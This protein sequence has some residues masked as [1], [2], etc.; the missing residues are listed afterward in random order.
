[1]C[2]KW[3]WPELTAGFHGTRCTVWKLE[4]QKTLFLFQIKTSPQIKTLFLMWIRVQFSLPTVY[5]LFPDIPSPGNK[6]CFLVTLNKFP[7]KKE[8]GN[9]I[10]MKIKTLYLNLRR[11]EKDSFFHLFWQ[12]MAW[13]KQGWLTT[14]FL[15]LDD[16]EV[17]FRLTGVHVS[18]HASY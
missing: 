3:H 7:N 10:F 15:E 1:M 11:K 4:V 14:E 16:L 18:V 2:H 5:F 13:G 17:E 9:A 12:I 8:F 6:K